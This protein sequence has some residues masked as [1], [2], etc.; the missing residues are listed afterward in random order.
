MSYYQVILLFPIICKI[1]GRIRYIRVN[2]GNIYV[3]YIYKSLKGSLVKVEVS[4]FETIIS[5]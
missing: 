5:H 4:Y 1:L 3:E 2:A